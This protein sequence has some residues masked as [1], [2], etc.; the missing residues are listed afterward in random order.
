VVSRQGHAGTVVKIVVPDT[1]E[2]VAPLIMGSKQPRVLRL[3]LGDKQD[4]S[5]SA[6]GA[7][8]A[9]DLCQDVLGRAIVDR[10]G[11]VEPQTVEMVL[12]NPVP[13]VGDEVLADRSTVGAIEVQR[14]S[15]IIAAALLVQVMTGKRVMAASVGTEVVVNHVEDH[16]EPQL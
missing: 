5:L 2:P 4:A 1:I 8:V 3:V 14:I 7:G 9:A 12:R 6:R 15:P 13:G 11:R 16:A 10:V